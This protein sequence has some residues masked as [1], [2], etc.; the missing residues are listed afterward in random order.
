VNSQNAAPLYREA[1]AYQE[2]LDAIFPDETHRRKVWTKVMVERNFDDEARHFLEVID[3]QLDR[4]VEASALSECRW[5]QEFY[6]DYGGLL[7]RGSSLAKMLLARMELRAQDGATDAALDDFIA[8]IRLS[9]NFEGEHR[10]YLGFMIRNAMQLSAINGLAGVL[11][12]KNEAAMKRLAEFWSRHRSASRWELGERIRADARLTFDEIRRQLAT[13]TDVAKLKEWMFHKGGMN[14]RTPYFE[15]ITNE[16]GMLAALK[17]LEAYTECGAAVCDH[18]NF[19]QFNEAR[20][21]FAKDHGGKPIDRAWWFTTG[22]QEAHGL[23]VHYLKAK[24]IEIATAMFGLAI[25]RAI[26]GE[27]ALEEVTDPATGRPFVIRAD[28][29]GYVIES[30]SEGFKEPVRLAVGGPD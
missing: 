25:Q 16:A 19:E 28:G 6:D 27:R 3:P 11:P 30:E 8:I 2:R 10:S 12:R 24:R 21:L 26:A 20:A 9:K 7:A 22:G 29:E 15:A 23:E 17:E 5:D 18:Q 14:P 4:V 13:G 1:F